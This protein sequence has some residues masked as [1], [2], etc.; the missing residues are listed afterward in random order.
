[1]GLLSALIEEY[2]LL[3]ANEWLYLQQDSQEDLIAP[4]ILFSSLK[5]L[6]FK[7]LIVSVKLETGYFDLWKM[8]SDSSQIV[9]MSYS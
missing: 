7:Q 3:M 8:I 9:L 1:M 5:I 6:N 4:I 2:W